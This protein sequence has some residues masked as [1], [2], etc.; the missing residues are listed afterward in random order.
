MFPYDPVLLAAV[1]TAPQSI[2]E[3]LQTM[4]T[5][6]GTCV[7]G[8][9]LKWFNG[10]YLQVKEAIEKR[11]ASGGFND[12]KWLAELDVQFA[13]LYFGAVRA[14]LSAQDA[15]GCWQALFDV[16]NNSAIAR[17]QFAMAGMNAHIIQDL[18]QPHVL[19]LAL[20]ATCE[21]TG[22]VP[23]HGGTH[24]NDYTAVNP[25]LDS[26]IESAKKTLHR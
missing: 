26:L 10:L 5:I 9:G 18:A 7:D 19:P 17:I 24:Y 6:D 3:V 21:V 20:V 4:H 16:R 13:S 12:P 1:Q 23:Q 14:A 25:T 2:A 11:V 22:T 15:A 8:D